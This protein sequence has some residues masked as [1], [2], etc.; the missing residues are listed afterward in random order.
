MSKPTHYTA[1]A[2]VFNST[3]GVLYQAGDRVPVEG[4]EDMFIPD[5]NGKVPGFDPAEQR[6]TETYVAGQDNAVKGAGQNGQPPAKLKKGA[7]GKP[8]AA[9]IEQLEAAVEV[10]EGGKPRAQDRV[11]GENVVTAEGGKIENV[12]PSALD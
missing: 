12:S 3:T 6:A 5:A 11:V 1:V 10:E 9:T 2:P 8:S 4:N 7:K